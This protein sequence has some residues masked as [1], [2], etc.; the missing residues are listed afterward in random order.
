MAGT[1][2][3]QDEKGKLV[4]KKLRPHENVTNMSEDG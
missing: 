1:A 3:E 4:A 2:K